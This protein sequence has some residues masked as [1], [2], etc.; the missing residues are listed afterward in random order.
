MKRHG[1]GKWRVESGEWRV[2]SEQDSAARLSL[3]TCHSP[4]QITF[5]FDKSTLDFGNFGFISFNVS[6]MT[7]AIA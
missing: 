3:A 1:G 4:L 7:F 6:T 5:T 2:E